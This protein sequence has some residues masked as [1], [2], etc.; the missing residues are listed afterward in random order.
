MIYRAESACDKTSC[1]KKCT[2]GK[3]E[4]LKL[5]SGLFSGG[6][7]IIGKCDNRSDC[8]C[9]TDNGVFIAYL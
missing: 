6:R 4:S 2:D 1:T 8:Y 7:K 9:E 5:K 3:S